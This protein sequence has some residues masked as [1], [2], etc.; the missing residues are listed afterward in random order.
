MTSTTVPDSHE[1]TYQCW[2]SVLVDVHD[3][4]GTLTKEQI[5]QR[6]R[7]LAIK[8]I[9]KMHAGEILVEYEVLR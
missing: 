2:V 3:D 4:S 9:P 1:V 8:H 6:A 5:E 7:D